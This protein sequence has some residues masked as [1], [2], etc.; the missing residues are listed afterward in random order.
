M[1]QSLHL[2]HR[3]K[4]SRAKFVALLLLTCSYSSMAI[5]QAVPGLSADQSEN[6]QIAQTAPAAPSA[7][8]V[9]QSEQLAQGRRME[10]VTV[11]GQREAER[12]VAAAKAEQFG[13][14]VQVLPAIEIERSGATNFAEAMQFLVKGVNIGYSPDEGEYTIR[15]DGG[16][17]RDTLVVLDGVPLYDRGPALEDIWGATTVDPHMIERVEVFRGGNSL[18]YGSNGGIGVVSIVTKKPDGRTKGEFGVNYGSFDT[19]ELWGNYTFPLDA[20]GDHSVMFYGSMQNTDGP[21]IFNPALFV[22]NVAAAGAIQPYPLNRNNIGAKY[23]WR[24]DD[25]TTLRVNG[26]Y[27]QVWFQDAFPGTEVFSPNDVRFP[28]VDA[29]LEKSWSDRA[30]TEFQVY[31]SNPSLRNTELQAE[32]CMIATGCVDPNVPTRRVAY[33]DWTGAVEPFANKGFGSTNQFKGGFQEMGASVRHTMQVSDFLEVAAGVQSVQYKDD[34]APVYPVGDEKTMVTGFFVDLRPKLPFSPDTGISLAGRIDTSSD[35]QDRKIWKFGIKHPFLDG[36]YVRANGGTS[37]SLPRNTELNANSATLIGNP[38]LKTETTET[39]NTGFGYNRDLG[40]VLLSTEIGA[41]RTNIK[42]RIQTTTGLTPNTYFNNAAV[43]KIKGLTADF[44]ATF[45]K[46]WR[47]NVSYTQQ[48]AALTSGPQKGWQINETPAWFIQSTL[49]WTSKDER[50]VLQLQPRLQG[51][52]YAT[53]GPTVN[54]LP[55]FRYDFGN[56]QVVNA[57]INYYMG[58]NSQYRLT[59]RAVNIFDE[60][61]AER[62]GYQNQLYGSAFNRKEYTATDPRYF[63]GYPFEGKPRSFFVSLAASF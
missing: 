22:D 14:Y 8:Q 3:A 39:Y 48:D 55:M 58:E 26:Q 61:Y 49:S 36:F 29:T 20:N 54:G 4:D 43:T 33:G 60:Y 42:N 63:Y 1:I 35:F 15:L 56:Y 45:D 12:S 52:E 28:I 62:Y 34:S 6:Q 38:N 53:G 25:T 50:L 46:Q 30:N 31:W 37:Y 21:R 51:A 23:L 7:D 32:I 13:N 17:D 19:R 16:G 18:F 57:N 27:T 59:L 2:S 44:D 11:L 24:M 47:I 41:F 10:E 40:S 9:A 5:A